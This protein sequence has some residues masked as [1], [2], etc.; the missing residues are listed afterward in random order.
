MELSKEAKANFV[1]YSEAEILK[2]KTEMMRYLK[3]II[4]EYDIIHS[5]ILFIEYLNL[6]DNWY[7]ENFV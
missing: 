7:Y 3:H 4:S 2:N 1:K 5:D 6:L